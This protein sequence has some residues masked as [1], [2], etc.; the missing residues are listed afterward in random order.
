MTRRFLPDL[1]AW[2][3]ALLSACCSHTPQALQRCLP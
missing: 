1:A 2:A 3:A